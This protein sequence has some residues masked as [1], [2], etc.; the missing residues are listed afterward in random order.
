MELYFDSPDISFTVTAVISYRATFNYFYSVV[1]LHENTSQQ[2]NKKYLKTL[3]FHKQR[4]YIP[5]FGRLNEHAANGRGEICRSD[6]IECDYCMQKS[7]EN[8]GISVW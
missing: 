3:L 7:S 2:K 5:H 8:L 4:R 1:V 6:S